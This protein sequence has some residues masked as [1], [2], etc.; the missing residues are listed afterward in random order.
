MLPFL[1]LLGYGVFGLD[2]TI[3]DFLYSFRGPSNPVQDVL[4]ITRRLYQSQDPPYTS[5]QS[6][7]SC[8]INLFHFQQKRTQA[9]ATAAE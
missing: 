6:N 7:L 4:L 2:R 9:F 8:A 3:T 5:Q 1:Q